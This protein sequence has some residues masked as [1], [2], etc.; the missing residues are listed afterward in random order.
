[1]LHDIEIGFESGGSVREAG[2][3]FTLKYFIQN[4]GSQD[5]T[6]SSLELELPD[7]IEFIRAGPGADIDVGPGLSEGIYMWV[8]TLYNIEGG[9]SIGLDVKLEALDTGTGTIKFNLEYFTLPSTIPFSLGLLT[10]QK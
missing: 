9:D 1:M 5:V 8:G 3:E 6:L 10:L 7:N 2:E 4:N